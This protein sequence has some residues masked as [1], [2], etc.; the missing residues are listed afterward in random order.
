M[1]CP[2][3][4]YSGGMIDIERD[5]RNLIS[6]QRCPNCGATFSYDR[7]DYGSEI[8][9]YNPGNDYSHTAIGRILIGAS[10][11]VTGCWEGLG[12][13]GG[14]CGI[15]GAGLLSWGLLSRRKAVK[16]AVTIQ[17]TYPHWKKKRSH[18]Q[19]PVFAQAQS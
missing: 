3:C 12:Y 10:I 8:S 7:K 13:S 17:K 9:V 6:F 2:V 15:I 18:K 14:L 11:F 4:Y 16:K 1:G 19:E 5:E